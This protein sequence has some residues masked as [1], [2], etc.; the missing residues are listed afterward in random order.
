MVLFLFILL[1]NVSEYPFQT[2]FWL[3]LSICKD[4]CK[5]G[6]TLG[7]MVEV[8]DLVPN[9]ESQVTFQGWAEV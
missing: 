2:E 5:G 8:V 6:E 7:T 1:T 9:R 3:R 4:R